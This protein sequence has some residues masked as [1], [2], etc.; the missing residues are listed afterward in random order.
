[1]YDLK[2][3]EFGVTSGVPQRS[4][5]GPLR[6]LLFVNDLPGVSQSGLRLYADNALLCASIGQGFDKLQSDVN[7]VNEW[8]R[9]W[10]TSFN[11]SHGAKKKPSSIQYIFEERAD[12]GIQLF[13][14]SRSFFN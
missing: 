5:L 12:S 13:K 10:Q 11:P 6:F 7:A 4:E 9:K 8:A 3:K 2:S 14:I 1:M